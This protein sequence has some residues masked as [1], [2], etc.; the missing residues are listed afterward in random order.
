MIFIASFFCSRRSHRCSLGSILILAPF[1]ICIIA[2]SMGEL[3]YVTRVLQDRT[4]GMTMFRLPLTVRG[5]FVATI[6]ALLV[7]P[8]LFVDGST[9]S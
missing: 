4:Y 7:F 6:L 8:A 5:V 3:N 9:G 1:I 2:A